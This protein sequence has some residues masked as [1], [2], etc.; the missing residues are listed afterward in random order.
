MENSKYP[1]QQTSTAPAL[2]DA[3]P[4]QC[5]MG[6]AYSPSVPPLPTIIAPRPVTRVRSL[7]A[8]GSQ[9]KSIPGGKFLHPKELLDVPNF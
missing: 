8:P 9:Q 2:A 1:E 7:K 6:W 3:S 5:D 4:P